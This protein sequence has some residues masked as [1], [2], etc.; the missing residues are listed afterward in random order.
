MALVANIAASEVDLVLTED[1]VVE[2]ITV[3]TAIVAISEV[4]VAAVTM[5]SKNRRP[6]GPTMPLK[7]S[8]IMAKTTDSARQRQRLHT[9]LDQY[10]TLIRRPSPAKPSA[11]VNPLETMVTSTISARASWMKLSAGADRKD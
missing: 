9:S 2:D 4:L 3:A 6:R 5:A 7:S 10:K 1:T 11:T 8:E